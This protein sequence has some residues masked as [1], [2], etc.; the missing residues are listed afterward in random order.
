[1]ANVQTRRGGGEG[2]SPISENV[3]TNYEPYSDP[4]NSPLGSRKSKTTPKLGYVTMMSQ[5]D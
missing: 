2:R 5:S 1:M 4:N 3:Q